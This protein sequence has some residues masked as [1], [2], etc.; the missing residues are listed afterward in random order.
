MEE[1]HGPLN[2]QEA[3]SRWWV[4]LFG[5]VAVGLLLAVCFQAPFEYWAPIAA[6][7]FL[8]LELYG[9]RDAHDAYPPLTQ[10]TRE[11]CPR[12]VTFGSI[13]GFV[14]LGGGTWFH[15]HRRW[16]LAALGA[17]LGWLVAHFDVTYDAPA[18]KQENAKYQWYARKLHLGRL[19]ERLVDNQ[20]ARDARAHV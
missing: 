3:W 15:F 6:V 4:L 13:F 17:L 19:Q 1:G 11:W 16:W 7:T 5:L 18:V 2:R 12:W 20:H 9:L 8:P 10:I 14:A